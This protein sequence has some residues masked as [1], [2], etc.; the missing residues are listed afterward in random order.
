MKNNT[1]ASFGQLI[2]MCEK[3]GWETGIS[4]LEKINYQAE[5]L[6]AELF[7][8]DYNQIKQA[9]KMAKTIIKQN[10]AIAKLK[11]YQKQFT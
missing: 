11:E 10:F 4:V 9:Q 6:Q 1:E 7:A 8:G 3:L 2:E 5:C